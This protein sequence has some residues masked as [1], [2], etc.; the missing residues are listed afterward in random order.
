MAEVAR[1]FDTVSVCLSN[2]LGAVLGT[3]LVG[4][5]HVIAKAGVCARRSAAE[6]FFYCGRVMRAQMGRWS[7][8]SR[9]SME[10]CTPVSP[11][12]MS[13]VTMMRSS[14]KTGIVA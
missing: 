1:P 14:A 13:S 3:V 5:A 11:I 7:D 2:G 4:K 8:A 6:R 12:S 10:R 9:A